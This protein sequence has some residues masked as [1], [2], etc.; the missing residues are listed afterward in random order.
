M[1]TR[2]EKSSRRHASIVDVAQ[3]CLPSAERATSP[4]AAHGMNVMNPAGF[5]RML[6]QFLSECVCWPRQMF[7]MPIEYITPI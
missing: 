1:L 7:S 6:V 5:A 2:G 4:D 3:K